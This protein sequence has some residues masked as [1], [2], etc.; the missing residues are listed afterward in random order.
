VLAAWL[1]TFF[2]TSFQPLAI[3][4]HSQLAL[5]VSCVCSGCC[6]ACLILMAS[7]IICRMKMT[8]PEI[9]IRSSSS[10]VNVWD[11]IHFYWILKWGIQG[12]APKVIVPVLTPKH[13]T[14]MVVDEEH[15]GSF[16]SA[17]PPSLPLLLDLVPASVVLPRSS[18]ARSHHPWLLVALSA[19]RPAACPAFDVMGVRLNALSMLLPD[20]GHYGRNSCRL[21]PH[22]NMAALLPV[23]LWNMFLVELPSDEGDELDPHARAQGVQYRHIHHENPCYV[24]TVGIHRAVWTP[25]DAWRNW[26]T[27]RQKIKS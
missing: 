15:K 25:K 7:A 3:L 11:A 14:D 21:F 24:S 17:C 6:A 9:D 20:W 18:A 23:D 13:W 16:H 22:Q 8:W 5:L 27:F 19:R 12:C 2:W 4:W 10:S 26:G 1:L